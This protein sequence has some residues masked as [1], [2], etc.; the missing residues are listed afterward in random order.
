MVRFLEQ[1]SDE[2]LWNQHIFRVLRQ[3]ATGRVPT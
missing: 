2:G 1:C 3:V